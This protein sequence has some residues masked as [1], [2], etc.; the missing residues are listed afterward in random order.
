M[1]APL[2]WGWIA[3]ALA[4]LLLPG[5]AGRWLLDLVGGLT[6]LLLLLPLLA[7]GAGLIAWQLLRRRL[8][9]CPACGVSSLGTS[10][11]PACGTVFDDDPSA[12]S[13]APIDAGSATITVNAVPVDKGGDAPGRS[14]E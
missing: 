2:P 6:L 14:P 3:L 8:R 5:P 10:Q 9:T 4:L 11:C 12:P 13:E 1:R 7:G